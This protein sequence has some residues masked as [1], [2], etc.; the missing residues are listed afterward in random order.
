M[1]IAALGLVLI[2]AGVLAWSRGVTG[3]AALEDK[4]VALEDSAA[5]LRAEFQRTN[6]LYK[7]FQ[8]SIPSLPDSV[9]RFG[10]G[11]NMEEATRY[12][13][14]L[15]ILGFQER[16]VKLEITAAGRRVEEMKSRALKSSAPLAGS[17]LAF[18]IAGLVIARAPRRRPVGA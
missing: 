14:K 3:L 1:A 7:G 17:G 8:E 5:A 16:D 12:T 15:R 9:R 10:T 4:R 13:K 18:F 11:K 2:A 6:L